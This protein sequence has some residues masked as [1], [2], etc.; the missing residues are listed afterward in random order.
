MKAYRVYMTGTWG[1]F[2][3]RSAW[4]QPPSLETGCFRP[5][6]SLSEA[7]TK[8]F[9]FLHICFPWPGILLETPKQTSFS[10]VLGCLQEPEAPSGR[11]GDAESPAGWVDGPETTRRSRKPQRILRMGINEQQR[12]TLLMLDVFPKQW[13]H[14]LSYNNYRPVVPSRSSK[15][16]TVN[17]S[18]S[19]VCSVIPD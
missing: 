4:F 12:Q 6:F 14:L 2:T 7:E 18:R 15:I 10:N 19:D 8:P 9:S 17:R 1:V 16:V 11:H 3:G 13:Q 5:A